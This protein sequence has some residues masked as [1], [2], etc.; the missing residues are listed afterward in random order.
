MNSS[1]TIREELDSLNSSLP[2]VKEPVFTVPNGYFENFAESVFSKLR[3][4][5]TLSVADELA[6]LSPLL[7]GLPKKSPFS[8]PENYFSS[9]ANDV[10]VLIG[11]DELPSILAELDRKLPYKVPQGYFEGLSTQVIS[12]T[13][14]TEGAKVIAMGR[15][16]WMRIAAAAIVT[17]VIALSSV[18]YFNS[19]KSIDP[20]QQSEA[21][22]AKNLQGV[23]DK[24]LEEF[25]NN[26]DV[27]ADRQV[28]QMPSKEVR[29]ML[30][31]VSDKEL[32]AFLSQLPTDDDELLLIN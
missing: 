15:P 25:V 3:D 22:V 5:N 20:D 19:N 31:D 17:G 24:A 9:L 12:K 18:V 4:Q 26:A 21:W 6:Q 7:A 1:K 11:N 14:G 16:R 13:K 28:A 32:D 29:T 30:G 27:S 10:P 2:P 8:V 23:S